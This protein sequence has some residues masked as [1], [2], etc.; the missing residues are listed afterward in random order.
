MLGNEQIYVSIGNSAERFGNFWENWEGGVTYV[1]QARRLHYG[2]GAFRLTQTYDQDLD[3]VVRER[4]FGVLGLLSYPFHKFLRIE[5]SVVARHSNEHRL[6][7]GDIR[8]LDLVT[9]GLA[10]VQDNTVWTM[11]GP[12]RGT[13]WYMAGSYTRDLTTGR[14]NYGT[15]QGE[16][17][18]YFQPLPLTISATRVVARSSFGPD[19]QQS[20]LGGLYT[21][22]GYDWRALSGEKTISVQQEFRAPLVRGLVLG[23]PGTF[24]LPPVGV[25]AFGDAG[26]AWDFLGERHLGSAGFG[27]YIGG[28]VYP[29]IRWNWAWRTPDFHTWTRQPVRQ[30]MIAY[31]F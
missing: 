30:F 4:R 23:F 5:G 31:D 15:L 6:R 18:G 22:R 25:A 17:R 2:A 8:S 28:G 1:N 24:P 20:Y 11:A 9:N 16:Y 21:L 27:V 29:S 7:N 3:A 10:L 26:F 13:R 14:G 19:A 12:T